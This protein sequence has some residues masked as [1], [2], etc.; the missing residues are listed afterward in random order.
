MS[1]D[2]V[3]LL[4]ALPD[5]LAEAE[6][7]RRL[8]REAFERGRALGDHEGYERASADL[9]AGWHV[10]AGPASRG[11]ESCNEYELR[12]WGQAG[13]A[14]FGDPRPADLTPAGMLTRARASWEPLGLPEPG[15]VP[16]AGPAGHW[17][18]PCL[19]VCYSYKAG[20]YP[21]EQAEKILAAV[22]AAVAERDARSRE[23]AAA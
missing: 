7:R 11:G 20:W 22:R 18:P 17:H 16:L 12:R 5:P 9:A 13:R 19:P 23:R 4:E 8:S 1:P 14:H 2:A 15:M 3:S 21:A 6:Y 10:V